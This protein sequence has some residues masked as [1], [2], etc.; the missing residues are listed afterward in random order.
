MATQSATVDTAFHRAAER[1]V[2]G[3][4]LTILFVFAA[5]TAVMLYFAAQLR[6]DAGFKKQIPLDHEYMRTFLDWEKEFGGAN[7][8]LVAVMDR[9][10]SMFPH[11]SSPAE[12]Q[13]ATKFFGAVERL[14]NDVIALDEVDDARVRSIFTP[15]VRFVEVVED[16]FAGGNVIPQEFVPNADGFVPN[17]ALFNTIRANMVKANAVGRFV[18]KD[19]SGAM[20][21]GELVPEGAAGQRNLDYQRVAGKLE[22]LRTKYET[23]PAACRLYEA[24]QK[25]TGNG[26]CVHI[27]GFQRR[28]SIGAHRISPS[29]RFFG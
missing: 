2:F 25:A 28:H 23:D 10:G 22:A 11:D 4:R 15:N 20:I 9:S 27:I 5:I 26:T 1:I 7:R 12:L 13:R 16:G 19:F 24:G 17:E 18:A 8:V 3:N 14:T 29:L 21:W 6:V